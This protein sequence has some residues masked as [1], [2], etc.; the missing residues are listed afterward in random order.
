MSHFA[1]IAP[2]FYSH[3]RALQ[4]LAQALIARGHRITFIQQADAAALL[5]DSNIGFHAIG[6]ATHPAGS[7]SHTLQ[8]AAHPTGLGILRLIRDMASSS[9]MLCR[10]LPAALRSLGIEGLIVDQMAPAG[11]LVA[12]ALRLPFVSVACALPVNREAHFPLP[13]MPFLWGTNSA[14]HERFASSEKIYDWMMRSHDRV[15]ARHARAFGLSGHHQPHQCLSP[16]AQIS[17]LPHALD[18][19]RR[20]LPEH[21]H[22][23]GPLREA[24]GQPAAPLFSNGPRPRIFASLGTLQGS[25]YGLFKTL[26]KACRELDAELLIA[27]CGGL[28]DFQARKLLRAGAARVT[29]FVDQRAALAQADVAVTHGGLNTVLDAVTHAT[30]LLAIPIA[31]D[32]PGIAARL[33]HHGLGIR[34]SRFATS[35]QLAR[36]LR[37][38]LEDDATR[39]RM[40]SL[41]PQ[42][43]HC[44]GVERA[45][46]ITAR[47]LLTRQPVRAEKHYD[48]AV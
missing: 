14:A 4:T 8:L 10:E 30:P 7:L 18:F 20:A 1:I 17:Q 40:A 16:L 25:R 13:V 29:D 32:Q 22:A 48:I 43:T 36:H 26:A 39:Q 21:F 12:D 33:V 35:H 24:P 28:S 45:A 5:S 3:M 42:L 27:H 47:A 31:F 15:L 41:K 2:P 46:E 44:G 38:L 19:P 9:D 11:G 23:T 34:A 37:H 6:Q